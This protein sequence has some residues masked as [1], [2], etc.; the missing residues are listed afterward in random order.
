MKKILTLISA[1][2][3]SSGI[4][5]A[6]NDAASDSTGLPGDNLDLYGVLDLFKSAAT[7]EDFEKSLNAES[8]QVNNLD[9]D[10]DG[11]VDYIKVIDRSDSGVHAITLQIDIT[12]KEAQD[13]AVIELEKTGNE[14][15]DLQIVG[16]EDLYG[17]DYIV[18]AAEAESINNEGKFTS[19]FMHSKVVVVNV[20]MWP[21][22]RYVYAPGYVVWVS[23]WRYRVYPPYYRPWR[24]VAWRVHHAR[25]VHYRVHYRR[26]H[27]HRVV[28]A[29][30][31]AHRHRVASAHYRANHPNHHRGPAHNNNTR[32]KQGGPNK[33]PKGGPNKGP[34]GGGKQGPKG[35]GGRRR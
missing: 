32:G 6:Q 10:K 24:P 21:C 34:K 25:V 15:A 11:N 19:G 16:D 17:E 20:W 14:S 27:A 23:P 5:N 29:H 30:R 33:G 8:N 1:A 18:E 4:A 31:V 2:I 35:G 12:D 7:M 22:V 28:R 26:V 13:V 9:L 3:L